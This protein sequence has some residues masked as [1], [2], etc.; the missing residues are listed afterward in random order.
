MHKPTARSRYLVLSIYI[1]FH[2]RFLILWA[3]NHISFRIFIFVFGPELQLLIRLQ[4]LAENKVVKIDIKGYS[5][6]KNLA[7]WVDAI[8]IAVHCKVVV[9]LHVADGV[10]GICYLL[11]FFTTAKEA[12][13]VI[14]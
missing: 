12:E 7:T 2:L 8:Y 3:L 13:V 11:E 10:T 1:K 9:E 6:I 4:L 14:L 5:R